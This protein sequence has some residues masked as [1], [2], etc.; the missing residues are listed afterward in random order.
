MRDYKLRVVRFLTVA[1][2][3][4][5]LLQIY[6]LP[7]QDPYLDLALLEPDGNTWTLGSSTSISENTT[8]LYPYVRNVMGKI[9]MIRLSIYGL[10]D[11][12]VGHSSFTSVNE[13][14][15]NT[16][17]TRIL[18]PDKEAKSVDFS[19]N[20]K[21]TPWVVSNITTSMSQIVIVL[22]I[23]QNHIWEIYDWVS[24]IIV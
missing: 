14:T 19:S 1:G 12:P 15:S 11:A 23:F 10:A 18:T 5:I 20:W 17:S 24:L 16:T 22:K 6:L 4:V 3:L 9:M 13:L 2:L 8:I 7:T 21:I